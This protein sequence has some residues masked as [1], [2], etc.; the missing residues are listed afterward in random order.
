MGSIY[1]AVKSALQENKSLCTSPMLLLSSTRIGFFF[2]A[3]FGHLFSTREPCE[4]Y[5]LIMYLST[6]IIYTVTPQT[7]ELLS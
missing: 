4:I 5:T 1:L 2:F 6:T 7:L 3:D